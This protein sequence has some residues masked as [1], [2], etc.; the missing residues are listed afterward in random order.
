MS[1]TFRMYADVRMS[2]PVDVDRD[3]IS[4]GGYE[5]VMNGRSVQFD[6]EESATG[7]DKDD[8]S[9]IHIE[10]RNPDFDEYEDLETLS[11]K[12][13]RNVEAIPEFFVYTGEPGESDL[14]PVELLSCTF[15]LPYDN[16]KEI[17]VSKEVCQ[18]VVMASDI[19]E[20]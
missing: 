19:E 16:W 6:F 14:R 2:R 17:K 12:D 3:Y 10:H 7:V 15:V 1:V 18:K 13:L 5:M 8:K 11:L 20:A 9:V 4:P